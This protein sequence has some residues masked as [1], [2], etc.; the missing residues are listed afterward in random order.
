MKKITVIVIVDKEGGISFGG[1]RQSRDRELIKDIIASTD[2]KIYMKEYSSKLFGDYPDRIAVAENPILKC[3]DGGAAFLEGEK[4][5]PYIESIGRVIVYTW[6]KVYP[7]DEYFD[8]PEIFDEGE[9]IESSEIKGFSHD[10]ITKEVL[11]I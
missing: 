3:P 11:E 1:K 5:G 9:L 2:G 8:I 7:T 4:I 10:V 6:D